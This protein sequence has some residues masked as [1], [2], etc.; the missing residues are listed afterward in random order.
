MNTRGWETVTIGRGIRASFPQDFTIKPKTALV[1]RRAVYGGAK[2][3]DFVIGNGHYYYY[4]Q[5]ITPRSYYIT[6]PT[7]KL[8][9]RQIK[10]WTKCMSQLAKSVKS[11]TKIIVKRKNGYVGLG[12]L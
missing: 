3:P 5:R 1:L 7:Y 4:I 12:A 10:F 2:N 8:T 11:K 9:D 6:V